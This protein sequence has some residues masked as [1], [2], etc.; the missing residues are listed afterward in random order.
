MQGVLGPDQF[1]CEGCTSQR[2]ARLGCRGLSTALVF[3]FLPPQW[4]LFGLKVTDGRTAIPPS[5]SGCWLEFVHVSEPLWSAPC[6]VLPAGPSAPGTSHPGGFLTPSSANAARAEQKH[7]VL[8]GLF[9]MQ[10]EAAG[11]CIPFEYG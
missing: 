10:C 6:V 1:H 2:G 4:V 11:V 8:Q 9:L 5:T 3:Y 7:C